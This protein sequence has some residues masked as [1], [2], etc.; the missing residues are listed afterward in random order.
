[1]LP[2]SSRAQT[3]HYLTLRFTLTLSGRY[4]PS[5]RESALPLQSRSDG[6]LRTS[7]TMEMYLFF[8]CPSSCTYA[9]LQ[10]WYLTTFAVA[11]QLYDALLTWQSVGS[12]EVT[13]TSLDFFQQFS[14]SIATGTYSSTDPQYT[15]LTSAIKT[16]ADGFVEIAANYTPSNGGLSE[17]YDKSTGAPVSAVDLTW[18]YA[19]VLTAGASRAGVEP[20]SWG[21]S[22]LTVPTQ[23]LPNPGPQVSVA[24]NVNATTQFG[25]TCARL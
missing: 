11:E 7:T 2:P 12:I 1:M 16:F 15:Q 24:F 6:T 18:S 22:G 5:I 25:G 3:R 9:N 14:T 4:I 13:T 19:S 10:P 20:A 17:Q 8:R 21:A 23:C